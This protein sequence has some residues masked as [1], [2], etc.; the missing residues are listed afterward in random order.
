VKVLV[1]VVRRWFSV[2]VENNPDKSGFWLAP[3]LG[4]AGI[5]AKVSFI[6]FF[7]NKEEYYYV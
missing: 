5:L 7:W 1:L 4:G 3:L 2:P 6:N